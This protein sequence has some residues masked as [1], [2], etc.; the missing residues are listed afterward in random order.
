MTVTTVVTSGGATRPEEQ[1]CSTCRLRESFLCCPHTADSMCYGYGVIRSRF[2]SSFSNWKIFIC[3]SLYFHQTERILTSRLED[4]D[5]H[6]VEPFLFFFFHH[7]V[8][9]YA[10]QT[11]SPCYVTGDPFLGSNNAPIETE[12]LAPTYIAL[13][14]PVQNLS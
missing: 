10:F 4:R 12:A 2:S 9:K 3:N 8:G 5:L 1:G 14:L 7:I 13:D 6:L 11:I